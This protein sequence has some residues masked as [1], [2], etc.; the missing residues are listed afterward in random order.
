MTGTS[1]HSRRWLV[2]LPASKVQPMA[3]ALRPVALH[4]ASQQ[5]TEVRPALSWPFMGRKWQHTHVGWAVGATVGAKVCSNAPC[6]SVLY[7]AEWQFWTEQG[8]E[9]RGKVLHLKNT[10]GTSRGVGRTLRHLTV[11]GPGEASHPP[12]SASSTWIHCKERSGPL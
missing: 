4:G 7:L 3:K 12:T 5:R 2:C 9:G 8:R 6:R 11:S 10:P 1:C